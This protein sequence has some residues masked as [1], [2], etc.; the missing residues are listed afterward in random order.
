[1]SGALIEYISGEVAFTEITIDLAAGTNI[2]NWTYNKDPRASEGQD[3]GFI[4]NL[5]FT[6]PAVVT[7][8]PTPITPVRSNSSGGGSLGWMMLCLF[9]LMVRLRTK[10]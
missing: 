10:I 5:V 7:P 2:I 9:G 1:M 3:K 6:P 4:R 8:P